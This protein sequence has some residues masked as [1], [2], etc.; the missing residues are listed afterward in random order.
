MPRSE[1]G[2]LK[3]RPR[4]AVYTRIGKYPLPLPRRPTRCATAK[5]R[6]FTV[7][8][9]SY[10]RTADLPCDVRGLV[11]K[12]TVVHGNFPVRYKF[13]SSNLLTEMA[14]LKRYRRSEKVCSVG[15]CGV[16]LL[17]VASGSFVGKFVKNF[18]LLKVAMIDARFA[19]DLFAKFLKVC[20]QVSL[21][22]K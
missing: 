13:L 5:I 11:T 22:L 8:T 10:V 9:A 2:V 15:S 14:T 12:Q 16:F 3:S 20:C 18:D 4:W 1:S 7:C 21:L 19:E 6:D 17:L